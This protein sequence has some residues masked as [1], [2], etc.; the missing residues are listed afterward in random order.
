MRAWQCGLASYAC[1]TLLLGQSASS[2]TSCSVG[3]ISGLLA[4]CLLDPGVGREHILLFSLIYPS[5]RLGRI[6]LI[7]LCYDKKVCVQFLC[8]LLVRPSTHQGRTGPDTGFEVCLSVCR[9]RP[10][11]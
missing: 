9:V 6:G 3:T 5:A 2:T 8:A 11:V 10:P 7:E 1:A 4:A